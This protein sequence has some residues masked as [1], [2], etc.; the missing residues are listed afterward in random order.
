MNSRFL[1]FFVAIVFGVN[2]IVTGLP[3]DTVETTTTPSEDDDNST[4]NGTHKEL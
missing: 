4:G 3:V 1:A 2:L